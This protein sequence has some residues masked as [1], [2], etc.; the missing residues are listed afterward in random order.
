MT[1]TMLK[2]KQVNKKNTRPIWLGGNSFQTAIIF[3][4]VDRAWLENTPL[5]QQKQV[6]W[7]QWD[8]LL[9]N[10]GED[11]GLKLVTEFNCSKKWE[12]LVMRGEKLIE[13]GASS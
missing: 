8:L 10:H 7:K 6:N 5:N 12:K 3:N 2:I 9:S 4:N 1:T 11:Q 13:G